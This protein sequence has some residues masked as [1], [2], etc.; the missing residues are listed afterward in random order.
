[1]NN[2]EINDNIVDS[3]IYV[4]SELVILSISNKYIDNYRKLSK[5]ELSILLIKRDKYPYKNLWCLPGR[6]IRHDETTENVAREIVTYGLNSSTYYQEQLYT[7][8][9]VD[10]S[11]LNRIISTAYLT[12]IDKN[13]LNTTFTK[14]ASW[15]DINILDK[16][17]QIIIDFDNGEEQFTITLEKNN[18]DS[19]FKYKIIS[20]D[21]LAFDHPLIIM[22]GINRLKSELEITD[23]VFNMM[24]P[25]FT[26]GELQQV[27]EVILNKKLL[28]PAF[29]RTIANKVVSTDEVKTGEG[30][31]PSILYKYK[32][33][34]DI[35]NE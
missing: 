22:E 23:I 31:R 17:N 5:K 9:S 32:E 16:N 15:F 29:R 14:N 28:D 26:L 6:T 21:F 11:P 27:Y 1:M 7:F 8:D 3:N 2:S 4:A 25:K 24:P 12:L 18:K 30:H 19:E 10:R 35:D 33:I 13:S 34:D 20:N